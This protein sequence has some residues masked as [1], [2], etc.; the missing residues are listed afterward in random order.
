[1]NLKVHRNLRLEVTEEVGVVVEIVTMVETI[2][3]VGKVTGT[4]GTESLRVM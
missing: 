1:M 3:V 2:N 4:A